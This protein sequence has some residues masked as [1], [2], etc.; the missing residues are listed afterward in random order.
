MNNPKIDTVLDFFGLKDIKCDLIKIEYEIGSVRMFMYDFDE[1]KCDST[2][3]K[4]EE[5][6]LQDYCNI[7][8]YVS[9]IELVVSKETFDTLFD[10]GQHRKILSSTLALPS[11]YLQFQY[12]DETE[13]INVSMYMEYKLRESFK[14]V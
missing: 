11:G 14:V 5:L 12:E 4:V 7:I 9:D 1:S 2:T 10:F 8:G 13:D 3:P 6:T